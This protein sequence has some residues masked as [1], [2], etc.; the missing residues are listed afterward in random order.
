MKR[1][2]F[3]IVNFLFLLLIVSITQLYANEF[4]SHSDSVNSREKKF[5]L[6]IKCGQGGFS[7]DRSPLG[8]LGGGQLALDIRP[9]GIPISFSISNEHYTNSNEPTEPFEISGLVAVNCYYSNYLF[10]NDKLNVFAGGG[11][12]R[13]AVQEGINTEVKTNLFDIEAGLNAKLMWKFGLYASYKY[14]YANDKDLI[15]FSEHIILIGIS[16]NFSL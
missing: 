16:F 12:G 1:I 9:R 8:I 15:N 7:D 6:T 5:N 11:L 13:L 2:K 4:I 14:L 3:Y 10:K